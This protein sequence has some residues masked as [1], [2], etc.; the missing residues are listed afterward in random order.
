[1]ESRIRSLICYIFCFSILQ[2]A[3][4]V[5]V[6]TFDEFKS[7]YQ[8]SST[9]EIILTSDLTATSNLGS[10]ASSDLIIIGSPDD[11]VNVNSLPELK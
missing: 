8:N 1:M 4:A 6:D 10:F 11:L 5:E 7:A 9:T 2:C 3:N